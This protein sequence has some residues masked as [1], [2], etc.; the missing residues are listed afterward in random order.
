MVAQLTESIVAEWS[1]ASDPV[2]VLVTGDLS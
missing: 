1:G 2:K